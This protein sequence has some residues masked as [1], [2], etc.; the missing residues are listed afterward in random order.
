MTS[1]SLVHPYLRQT[2]SAWRSRDIVFG[3]FQDH[4]MAEEFFNTFYNAFTSDTVDASKVTPKAITKTIKDNIKHDNFYGTY[5]KPPKLDNIE[6]YVWWKE[7]LVNDK[8]EEILIKDFS[9]EDKKKFSYEQKMIALIQQSV[10]DD[11]FSLLIHDGSSKSVWKDLKAKAKGEKIE[12]HDLELQKQSKMSSS[13]HHQN[14]GL[15][16]KGNLPSVKADSSPKTTFSGEKMKEPQTT[17]SNYH[18]GYDSSS[19]SSSDEAEDIIKE[20]PKMIENIPKEKSRAYAVI[21]DDE[22]FDWS[23][24]LPDEDRPVT[25]HGRKASKAQHHVLVAEIREENKE[26]DTEI[27]EKTREEILS[28]KTERERFIVGCRMEKMQEEYENVVANKRW[29]KKQECY[30]NKQGEPVVPRSDIVHDDVLLVISRSGEYYSSVA[31]DKT[32]VKRLDK[33]IRDAMTTKLRKR[34]KERMKKNIENLVEDLKKAAEEVKVEKV[35]EEDLKVVETEK[36]EEKEKVVEKEAVI[37][38]QQVEEVKKEKENSIEV[39]VE[40][41]TDVAG[42]VGDEKQQ[43]EADQTETEANTKVPITEK[44]LNF[45]GNPVEP[46]SKPAAEEPAKVT[47]KVDDAGASKDAGGDAGTNAGE[48]AGRDAGEDFDDEV[49]MEEGATP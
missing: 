5:S 44:N 25:A 32:Y 46:P 15:Y 26:K 24:I 36:V 16:Y 34:N 17:S 28:E 22:G 9:E 7:S 1:S 43:K 11:I 18:S 35:K 6:D 49:M 2:F 8:G 14:V 30:V 4:I 23:Q 10:R 42:D 21:H 13:S 33:I 37:E 39:K 20:E 48:D 47:E 19:K 38:E 41:S 45:G 27:K 40:S 29:D 3:V 12:S 31:K